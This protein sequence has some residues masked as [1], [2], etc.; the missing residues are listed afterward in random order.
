M[1]EKILDFA[2]EHRR[3][4]AGIV[5]YVVVFIV[6]LI[7]SPWTSAS[8]FL[9]MEDYSFFERIFF[10]FTFFGVLDFLDL[11]YYAIDDTIFSG[12]GVMFIM[13]G[14]A[15]FSIAK[16]LQDTFI[17]DEFDDLP[18]RLAVDFIYDNIFAYAVCVLL[19]N[20]YFPI[21]G[22]VGSSMADSGFF[23]KAFIVLIVTAL[24]VV[25]AI[26]YLVYIIA[27]LL[28]VM[29]ISSFASYL[30]KTI[31]W[32]FVFAKD[33][34]IYLVMIVLVLIMSFLVSGLLGMMID[35][36][37][38]YLIDTVPEAAVTLLK[39]IAIIAVLLLVLYLVPIIFR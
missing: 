25:P 30:D 13:S 28:S 10:K 27:Y 8:S 38:E 5:L 26:P 20:A 33:L 31:T 24:I 16:F 19:F 34:L 12:N 35:N 15:L 17:S 3:L 7:Y 29:L 14:C 4:S 9:S 37:K 1:K 23:G 21:A 2:D 32:S 39:G 36:L 18:E 22:K 6:S 11:F